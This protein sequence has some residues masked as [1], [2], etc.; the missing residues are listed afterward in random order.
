MEAAA[1][2][3][4]CVFTAVFTHLDGQPMQT[5]LIISGTQLRIKQH[6]KTSLIEIPET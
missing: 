3:N 6:Q 1:A 5:S 4:K 2:E